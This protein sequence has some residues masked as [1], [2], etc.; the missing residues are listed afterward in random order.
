MKGEAAGRQ[1]CDLDEVASEPRPAGREKPDKHSC[2]KSDAG[3]ENSKCKDPEM[4]TR[5]RTAHMSP[6]SRGM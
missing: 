5:F 4:G 2:R 3:R 1:R 6:G